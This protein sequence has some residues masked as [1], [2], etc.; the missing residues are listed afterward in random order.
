MHKDFNFFHPRVW[1]SSCPRSSDHNKCL[2]PIFCDRQC[3]TLPIQSNHKIDQLLVRF[4]RFNIWTAKSCCHSGISPL[5]CKIEGWRTNIKCSSRNGRSETSDQTTNSGNLIFIR[6]CN[7][8]VWEPRALELSRGA[9]MIRLSLC[10]R[11][12]NSSEELSSFTLS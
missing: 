9:G 5:K 2:V 1:T 7:F 3:T 4:P 6:I 10:L 8:L 12:Q 11:S